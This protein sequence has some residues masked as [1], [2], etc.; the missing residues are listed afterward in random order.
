MDYLGYEIY[1]EQNPDRYRGG[2]L[3][4]ICKDGEELDVIYDHSI[5][6]AI[7]SAKQRIREIIHDH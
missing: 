3:C 2:Y 6:N 7:D 1:T 4:S 5:L